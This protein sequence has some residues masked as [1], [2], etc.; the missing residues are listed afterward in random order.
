VT[1][2]RSDFWVSAHLRR[3]AIEGVNA[4][5]RRRGAAEAGAIFVKLDRLDGSADLYGPAPQSL[6][7]DDG[8]RLFIHLIQEGAHPQVEERMRREIKFD[9]DLWL[10]EI[11]DRAGRTFLSLVP[12]ADPRRS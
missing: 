1:R 12:D 7:A 2:L 9:P 6:L 10:I 8:E 5:L 4:V 3:C 11:E